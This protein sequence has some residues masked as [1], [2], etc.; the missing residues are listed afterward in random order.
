MLPYQGRREHRIK[1]LRRRRRAARRLVQPK[2]FGNLMAAPACGLFI[3]GTDTAVGK[4]YVTALI[5]R[6]L[7]AA[8]ARVGVY[9]PLASGCLLVDERLVSDDAR[10][11]WDAAGRPGSLDEVCPQRF[12][13]PLAPHLAARAENREIDYELIREQFDV[14]RR[15]SDVVL[16]EGAGGLMSPIGDERYNADLAAELGLPVVIVAPNRVGVIHQTLATLMAAACFEDGLPVAGIVLNQTSADL[17]PSVP[18]NRAELAARAVPPV[19][20]EVAFGG[21]FS[22]SVDWLSL[23]RGS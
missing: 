9:K 22:E 16:V 23:A 21:G 12:A 3:T 13:A 15:R 8:G 2:R 19:L 18:V 17:D 1:A 6:Q 7:A 14:W 4:T 11:L 10:Q 5:A 20:A